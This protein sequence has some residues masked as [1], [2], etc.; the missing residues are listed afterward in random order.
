MMPYLLS[1]EAELLL[2]AILEKVGSGD[3][4]AWITV[5]DGVKN[6]RTASEELERNGYIS[7]LLILEKS[8]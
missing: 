4:W 5:P 8:L 2:N 3:G 7:S 1:E 6:R